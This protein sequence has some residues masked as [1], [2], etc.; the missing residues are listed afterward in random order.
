MKI[1]YFKANILRVRFGL[2][3]LIVSIG[4]IILPL[5]IEKTEFHIL[6]IKT[7]F[8][9]YLKDINKHQVNYNNVINHIVFKNDKSK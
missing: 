6:P 1:D 7:L 8:L 9:L 4:L 5:P 2:R 3:R